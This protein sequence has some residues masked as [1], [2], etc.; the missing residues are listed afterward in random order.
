MLKD[1]V[2]RLIESTFDIG[3]EVHEEYVSGEPQLRVIPANSG[4]RL[5][6]IL[7]RFPNKIRLE[8][9]FLPQRYSADMVREMGQA[10][11]SRKKV[12]CSYAEQLSSLGAKTR[13]KINDVPYN[14]TDF[15]IWP[16]Q[17]DKF[18][19]K[20]DI[21]PIEFTSYDKP[22]YLNTVLRW[23]PLMMGLS[24]SLLH[25]VKKEEDSSLTGSIGEAEGKK[26]D[27]VTSRYE[28]SP[29]NR[30]LC[31]AKYGY[32]CQICGF[33][34]F[35][36]YGDIG[37]DFIHVHH[38]VPVSQMGENYQV[39]PLKELIP[40]CPNCHAMLHRKNPPYTPSELKALIESV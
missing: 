35:Q 20:T 1:E 18:S 24:L 10:D 38:T 13:L 15:V 21:R 26:Y 11:E 19:V 7:I 27:V 34:F 8:M 4:D 33:D 29:V 30:V 12:F 5:F 2:K 23:M 39:D 37:K 40:V 9:S 14:P 31:L 36:K 25:V 28:R 3:F 16:D 32:S 6:E 22:D 17:W